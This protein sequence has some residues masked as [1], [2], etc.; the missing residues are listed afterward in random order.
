MHC[1]LVVDGLSYLACLYIDPY[2]RSLL[3]PIGFYVPLTWA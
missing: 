2:W 3:A 1:L